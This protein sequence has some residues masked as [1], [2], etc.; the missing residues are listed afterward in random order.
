MRFPYD[1]SVNTRI[2]TAFGALVVSGCTSAEPITV[3]DAGGDGAGTP[4]HVGGRAP[5]GGGGE[6]HAA[7]A[8]ATGG[9]ID[10]GGA[11]GAGGLAN[12]GGAGGIPGGQGG[13]PHGGAGG[14][15]AAGG[16]AGSA[17]AGATSGEG[18]SACVSVSCYEGPLG[19]AGV[20]V[21]QAGSSCG[22]SEC[23]GQAVPT[24]EQCNGLDD[25]CDGAIDNGLTGAPCDGPDADFCEEG[26]FTC[27]STGPLCNDTTTDAVDACDWQDNDCNGIVD[28]APS[29]W[30]TETV[31]GTGSV[32]LHT[33][34]ALDASG[35][36]HVAFYESG[37][38]DLKYTSRP[39]GA[40]NWTTPEPVDSAGNVGIAVSL[41]VDAGGNVHAVYRDATDQ[42]LMSAVRSFATGVWEQT[43]VDSAFNTGEDPA[44]EVGDDGTVH[45]AYC[46]NEGKRLLY[47]RLAPGA[48]TWEL[49]DASPLV[50]ARAPA[51]AVD[52]RG[53]VHV[54]YYDADAMTL[55]YVYRN[56][57]DGWTAPAVVDPVL[58]S[59]QT[60]SIAVD[61]SGGLHLSYYRA[62]PD[63]A[64]RYATKPRGGVWH[65][66]VQPL[67]L[68]S[69][70]YGVV[71]G[72]AVDPQ[73]TVHIGFRDESE[74]RL[75]SA[76]KQDGTWSES[77][78]DAS[79]N[80]G[81]SLSLRIDRSGHVGVAY[82]DATNRDVKFA[83]R[84][85]GALF[86][87]CPTKLSFELDASDAD[88]DIGT[89]GAT[90]NFPWVSGSMLTMNVAS[91]AG[92]SPPCGECQLQGVVANRGDVVNGLCMGMPLQQ[93]MTSYQRC[94]TDA[95]CA[96]GPCT[97]Y[98]GAPVPFDPSP[99][100]CVLTSIDALASGA[101]NLETGVG[102][103]DTLDLNAHIYNGIAHSTP[104]PSCQEDILP[105][106]GVRNGTCSGGQNNGAQCDAEGWSEAFQTWSSLD[107]LPSSGAKISGSGLN[108]PVGPL[109]TAGADWELTSSS[110]DCTGL[111]GTKCFCP[112]QA[113][114]NGCSDFDGCKESASG[115]GEGTCDGDTALDYCDGNHFI[116][117]VDDTVCG[118]AGA[119]TCEVSKLRACFPDNGAE[120]AHLVATGQ[121][122]PISWGEATLRVGSN[123]CAPLSGGNN[124]I[125]TAVGLP[126]P[127]RI[128]TSVH[129][130]QWFD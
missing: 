120:G 96:S 47:A 109:G 49:E 93:P 94:A 107:C 15:S 65:A 21:C 24:G 85:T 127:G 77:V 73:G 116:P 4:T 92:S 40:S 28:D 129:V 53:V 25:D 97:L 27:T 30:I 119:G 74:N 114:S 91:C 122:A 37:T 3:A 67:N 22:S 19:T 113:R 106:D 69:N 70:N 71:S 121:P 6:S 81:S 105:G 35:G 41:A 79:V 99:P 45:V 86:P 38:G 7:G 61:A 1:E 50:D 102:G 16:A 26:T 64:L 110:P 76:V 63:R 103:L 31:F 55:N 101:I 62:F 48:T 123:F 66:G 18:G 14:E 95:D 51:L 115:N 89:K 125:N 52:T 83:S 98:F 104:C 39:A 84:C 17:A 57:S 75:M 78:I 68:A 10:G 8:G 11:L 29:V 34:L 9:N 72:I 32:G 88:I 126:G 111:T 12:T 118:Q 42:W 112:A 128:Q 5:L 87:A 130:K 13:A 43:L 59:G 36:A 23:A 20:G 117:C 46:R 2:R 33:A 82:Y 90:H 44:I 108:L 56:G 54:S 100:I 80:A 124:S 58:R 60:S